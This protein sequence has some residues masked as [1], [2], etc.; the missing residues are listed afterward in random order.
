[1]LHN[2]GVVCASSHLA[3]NYHPP[4]TTTCLQLDLTYF[5]LKRRPLWACLFLSARLLAIRGIR[6][7]NSPM[8]AFEE[9]VYVAL[10]APCPYSEPSPSD[11]ESSQASLVLQDLITEDDS[12]WTA[13]EANGQKRKFQRVPDLSPSRNLSSLPRYHYHGLANTQTQTQSC[14]EDEQLQ[15]E[16]LRKKSNKGAAAST[17]TLVS[18]FV[19][20]GSNSVSYKSNLP[21]HNKARS[22][23]LPRLSLLITTCIVVQTRQRKA[24][25]NLCF[26]IVFSRKDINRDTQ[27]G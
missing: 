10:N 12:N 25:F 13:N 8:D 9:A 11:P 21:S 4:P 6:R 26:T 24:G 3:T 18:G 7:V 27:A 20:D 15:Q 23:H 5:K 19:R 14:D 16:N 17:A 1:M 22:M 2:F